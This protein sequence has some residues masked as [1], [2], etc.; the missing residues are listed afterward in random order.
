MKTLELTAM[1]TKYTV[2]LVPTCYRDN[3]TLAIQILFKD[4]EDWEPYGTLTT[5]LGDTLGRNSAYVDTNNMG[6]DIL[7]WIEKNDLGK[8]TGRMEQSGFCQY[9]E[10]HFNEK[11]LKQ[12]D[13]PDYQQ[14]LE[15]QEELGEG[16]VR[17]YPA[18]EVCGNVYPVTVTQEQADMYEEYKRY[19]K[20]LIQDVFP[21]MSNE[22]R[23]LFAR[24]QN[25]CGKCWKEMFGFPGDDKDFDEEDDIDGEEV[26]E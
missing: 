13:S 17:L 20:Y 15:L 1:D 14:Y 4:G 24:G 12:F 10:V 2:T 11:V 26:F 23:G 25:I 22:M 9:P 6:H 7:D 21:D 5:N 8:P 18:C 19:G 16:M 3:Q